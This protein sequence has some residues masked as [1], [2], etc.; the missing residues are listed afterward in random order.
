MPALP[1][2]CPSMCV[3]YDLAGDELG[4]PNTRYRASV[5]RA[6][7]LGAKLTLHAGES[8]GAP[9]V[10]DSL[11]MGAARIGHGVRI[12][13]DK[14]VLDRVIEEKV[15][16]EMC[17]TSN[18]QTK[19]VKGLTDHPVVQY[20]RMGVWTVPC[21][22]NPVMSQVTSSSELLKM[23]NG[24]GATIEEMT[25][26]QDLGALSAFICEA[27]RDKL[28][29]YILQGAVD[30]GCVTKEGLEAEYAKY[31]EVIGGIIA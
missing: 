18:Q 16:L 30:A 24:L 26:M 7:V 9:N 17:V 12:R 19:C 29:R 27:D 5:E 2:D 15:P 28:R 21:T 22:D 20:Y 6:K 14:A 25:R 1:H 23:H 11:D 10:N 13:E 4:I 31:G 8:S 3:G